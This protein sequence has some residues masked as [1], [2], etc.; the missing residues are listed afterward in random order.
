MS[1]ARKT[2]VIFGGAGFIGHHLASYLL[3]SGYDVVVADLNSRDQ[4]NIQFYKCDVRKEIKLKFDQVPDLVFLLSAVHRSPG[5]HG[6]EYYETNVAGAT[7]VVN[8]CNAV[9]ARKIVFTSSIAVYGPDSESKNEFS[10]LTPVHAYGKSKML[11]ENILKSW[12]QEDPRGRALVVCRPAVIFGAGERGN[13]TRL[14]KALKYRLF[15]Y[16]GG[17][18]TVKSCGYVK[19]LVRSLVFVADRANNTEITYN[20]C[21]PESYSIGQIC[22]TFHSVA[23]YAKP[24]SLPIATAGNL[25]THF[26]GPLSTLGARVLK[27]VR[28]TNISPAVLIEM[29]FAWEW[30]LKS[31]LTDWKANSEKSGFFA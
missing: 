23:G 1:D 27:L 24:I 5:H 16:P 22:D 19:D 26:P 4:E 31:A 3:E 17:P 15:F 9:G 11:S 14:A 28:A 20:F 2:A 29:D 21:Y 10:P 6:D 25:L 18:S 12:Q 13:F 8:W 30:D 7:N